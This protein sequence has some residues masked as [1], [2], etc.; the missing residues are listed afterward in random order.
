M[1]APEGFSG[2]CAR[3]VWACALSGGTDFS[4]ADLLA[5][6]EEINLAVNGSTREISDEVQYARTEYW[7]LP[8]A[9][10]GDCE[11]FALAKKQALIARGVS[12]SGC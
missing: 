8:T 12:P 7:A 1:G 2:V 4:T 11:D 5:Y 3:Y 10:G 9:R 6:A